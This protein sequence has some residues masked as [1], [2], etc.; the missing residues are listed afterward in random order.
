MKHAPRDPVV[1]ALLWNEIGR[2][3][4]RLTPHPAYRVRR[5]IL[6]LFGTK[7]TPRTKVLKTVRIDRPWN[8]TIGERTNIGDQA[9]IRAAHPVRIGD[10][11]TLSQFA[12]LTTEMRDPVLP[13][14]PV[15]VGPIVMEDDSWVAADALV[16]PGVTVHEGAVVG[17]RSL[18]VEDIA[19][20]SIATG[21]P[22]T[23]RKTRRIREL[24]G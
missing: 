5:S 1:R 11:C 20:W 15:V 18:V 21:E 16:L 19:P 2:F 8:L 6:R 12:T 17:A 24:S 3:V 22:A 13:G 4:F 9:V 23:A 7:L 10:R 14:H